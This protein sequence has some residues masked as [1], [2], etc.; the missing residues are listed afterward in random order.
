MEEKG[1]IEGVLR[2]LKR[3]VIR[4]GGKSAGPRGGSAEKENEIKVDELDVWLSMVAEAR[5]AETEA[6]DQK[7]VLLVYKNAFEADLNALSGQEQ[8]GVVPGASPGGTPPPSRVKAIVDQAQSKLQ[9][10][11]GETKKWSAVMDKVLSTAKRST[12]YANETWST[13]SKSKQISW[14]HSQGRSTSKRYNVHVTREDRN[15]IW[16]NRRRSGTDPRIFETHSSWSQ[17]APKLQATYTPT[18]SV[19]GRCDRCCDG[20]DGLRKRS[21]QGLSQRKG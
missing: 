13:A 10:L 15:A 2:E 12:G 9:H 17:T 19:L 4:S 16:N 21:L 1:D 6:K 8:Q 7:T 14:K 11:S 5:R 3:I 18:L 20:F